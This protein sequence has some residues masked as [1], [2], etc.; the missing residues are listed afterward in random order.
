MTQ[1]SKRKKTLLEQIDGTKKYK[2]SKAAELLTAHSTVKFTESIDIAI[3]LGVDP[4]KSDQVVR[5]SAVLPHGTG[6][7]VRVYAICKDDV[8]TAALAAGAAKAG[9]TE[10]IAELAKG[11]IHFD[12]LIAA[13]DSMALLGKYGQLLGPRG[14]MP[15]P[16]TG[17]VNADVATAVRHA[18]TGQVRFRTDKKGIIHCIVGNVSYS[19]D[20]IAENVQTLLTEIKRLKPSASKGVYL[21]KATLSS[22]MGPGLA[23]ELGA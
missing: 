7:T 5:G 15:N 21:K 19:G 1:L 14:L 3:N 11:E 17:T 12:V 13:P 4:S 2:I 22:T 10:I 9:N 16:K 6:K 8:V 20:N 18:K 23:V